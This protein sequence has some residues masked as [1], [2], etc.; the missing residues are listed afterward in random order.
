M[1]K[2]V[3]ILLLFIP[4]VGCTNLDSEM[5]D[6]INPTIFPKTEE[7][8][9]AL[10]TAAAY[11]P[12][13]SNFW[14][15]IF[16]EGE[17]GIQIIGD[18]TTDLGD[19]NWDDA[20]WTGV[21]VPEYTPYTSGVTQFYGYVRNISKMTLAISRIEGVDMAPEKKARL[22]AELRCGRGWMAYLLYDWFGPVP[23]ATLE[24]LENPLQE[25]ILPRPTREWMVEYIE[26]ELKE[27]AKVLPPVYSASSSDY[28]RMN[29][30][31]AYTVLMKLYM[32]EGR[33]SDAVAC[34]REL[35][36]A[37]YGYALQT[38]YEDIFTLENERNSEIIWAC[39][40]KRD[41][42]ESMWLAHVL[43]SQ[44][45][46]K[47]ENI[48]KWNGYR[49]P[50]AFYHTFDPQDKR[51]KVLVGEFTDEEGTVYNEANPGTGN[52]M[53]L[54]ALP[55]KYGE[56]PN[57]TG[58]GSEV[59]WV[60]YRY[61]DVMLL[62]AE[63]LVREGNAV[64][65]EAAGLFSDVRE[66][67]GLNRYAVGDFSGVQDFLDKILLERGHELWFEGCRRSDLIRHGKYV[68]KAKEKGS[69]TA[70]DHFNVMPLP[71]SAITNG[72]GI[73]T[74]NPVY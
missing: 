22:I 12:F 40:E 10:V 41:I 52:E 58:E 21:L 61:A 56:D 54:G 39:Q 64:T 26:T 20:V 3:Y 28:G 67:A 23:V 44:Y 36:K 45:I 46:T 14:S 47:N 1:K 60:V 35:M 62:M 30:G 71:Q 4:A 2:I 50:W 70:A 37:D 57:A 34:G 25:E 17:G 55:V 33:W 49:V 6:V 51:L 43:P 16:T 32:H 19:C 69:V 63:A 65:S 8:A 53:T 29:A 38:N 15:G 73:V 27:A 48:Q 42:C 24:Q 9:E 59:D 66:R 5:Y 11:A 7:D 31:L 13:W 68:E 18:M 74:Q 72:K